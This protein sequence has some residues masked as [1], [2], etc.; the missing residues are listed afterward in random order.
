MLAIAVNQFVKRKVRLI[1]F[2]LVINHTNYNADII[3]NKF[4]IQTNA[5]LVQ[6]RYKNKRYVN[7]IIIRSNI[8]LI[9]VKKINIKNLIARKYVISK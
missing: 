2:F 6:N 4:V 1:H 3:V 9:V 7:V 8:K 5:L